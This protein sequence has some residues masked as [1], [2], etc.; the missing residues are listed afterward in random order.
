MPSEQ[1]C[2]KNS[3][4]PGA[5]QVIYRMVVGRHDTEWKAYAVLPV[6]MPSPQGRV[7]GVQQEAVDII[8]PEIE[9]KGIRKVSER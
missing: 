8:V 7:I 3:W 4:E 6:Q 9:G 1:I 5:E 2:R